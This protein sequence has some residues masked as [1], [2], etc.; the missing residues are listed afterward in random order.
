MS[1]ESE[2][3]NKLA[4][5]LMDGFANFLCT[6]DRDVFQNIHRIKR[7]LKLA[8]NRFRDGNDL[9][10]SFFYHCTHGI[11]GDC[12]AF[13]CHHRFNTVLIPH[14]IEMIAIHENT[15]AL[16]T[17]ENAEDILTG[18][19]DLFSMCICLWLLTT[20]RCISKVIIDVATVARFH[21]PLFWRLLSL[22]ARHLDQVELIGLPTDKGHFSVFQLFENATK[23]SEIIIAHIA[24]S[25]NQVELLCN[26]LAQNEG[27]ER[28]VLKYVSMT[29]VA[30]QVLSRAI[31]KNSRP[32]YFELREKI[33]TCETYKNAVA[34]LLDT[35][36]S[37]LCLEAPCNWEELFRRLRC[38]TSLT[39]LEIFDCGSRMYTSLKDLAGALLENSTL[40]RLKLCIAFPHMDESAAELWR[41]LTQSIGSNQ[42]LKS[43]SLASWNY[44][45]EHGEIMEELAEAI[46]Q[47]KT[48]VE[49][50]VEDFDLPV[51]SLLL[52]FG[53]LSLN[54]KMETLHIGA[55]PV[56]E[57]VNRLVLKRVAE[58][59]LG[60][61]VDC[62]Y[63][64]KSDWQLDQTEE[65]YRATCLR[66][67]VL[68][69]VT[70]LFDVDASVAITILKG[71]A[72]SRTLYTVVV[73]RGWQLSSEVAIAFGE[74]LKKN[75]S[76]AELTVWQDNRTGFEELKKHLRLGVKPN[77][78]ISKVRL[79]YGPEKKES[80]DWE[81]FQMLQNNRVVAS[82]AADAVIGYNCTRACMYAFI[83][84]K[85][86]NNYRAVL[87]RTMGCDKNELESK[88]MEACKR[89]ER[90]LP[91]FPLAVTEDGQPGASAKRTN[92]LRTFKKDFIEE[93]KIFLVAL[94]LEDKLCPDRKT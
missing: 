89:S 71:L 30:L 49:L 40:R 43:L 1:S 92:A 77:Y 12:W 90:V 93:V 50:S 94:N 24:L 67:S 53:G 27:L 26:V 58:L 85:T 2:Q 66:S 87:R 8:D 35:P 57:E 45:E 80:C 55:L 76:I 48:L 23:L 54:D 25:D 63:V 22:N 39:D 42:G 56:D 21:A 37:K 38:N 62:M 73:G 29:T 75:S 15:F 61:R 3:A 10:E 68:E 88:I 31:I 18:P 44:C 64:L 69:H 11:Q 5:A 60:E 91:E 70:L 28:L 46:A 34:N 20:H 79:L 47:N 52:L 14:G 36:V 78:A 86:C 82:W 41:K 51:A 9:I 4:E 13:S 16:Q 17:L 6:E 33:R 59:G 74:T 72:S 84:M 7:L 81:L 83:R 65:A 32:A 19:H